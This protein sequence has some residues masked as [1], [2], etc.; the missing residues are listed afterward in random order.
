M[1]TQRTMQPDGSYVE[2]VEE[3][4]RHSV[5]VAQDVKGKWR[6]TSAKIYFSDEQNA[7]EVA[8]RLSTIIDA[9]AEDLAGRGLAGDAP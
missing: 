4:H 1:I 8:E 7:A 2:T 9:V 5:E 6:I 3:D